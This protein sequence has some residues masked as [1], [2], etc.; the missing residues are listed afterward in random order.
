[1]SGGLVKYPKS[2][3]WLHSQYWASSTPKS[4]GV[5]TNAT[6]RN[7]VITTAAPNIIRFCLCSDAGWVEEANAEA[8]GAVP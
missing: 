6:L 4:S 5:T 3:V 2:G 1:M 7:S 8:I